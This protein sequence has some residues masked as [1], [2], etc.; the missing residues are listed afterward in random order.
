MDISVGAVT[1][2]P[3][4]FVAPNPTTTTKFLPPTATSTATSTTVSPTPVS[5]AGVTIHK[6]ISTST[7][8]STRQ[9]E[10]RWTPLVVLLALLGSGSS[11]VV[12][13]SGEL[14][15]SFC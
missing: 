12:S 15:Q 11:L 1:F 14:P 7:S 13:L 6:D 4:A 2:K 3:E 8:T 9:A 5:T 10:A